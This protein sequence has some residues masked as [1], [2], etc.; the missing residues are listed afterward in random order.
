MLYAYA[1]LYSVLTTVCVFRVCVRVACKPFFYAAN[2]RHQY[3][4]IIHKCRLHS[5]HVS[6]RPPQDPRAPLQAQRPEAILLHPSDQ[7]RRER[8]GVVPR[9]LERQERWS[10]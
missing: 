3:V 5:A 2:Q 8:P 10:K 4:I 7:Y 6:R 1:Y 9:H